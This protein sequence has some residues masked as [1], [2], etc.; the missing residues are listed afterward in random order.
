MA[1]TGVTKDQRKIFRSQMKVKIGKP[2]PYNDNINEMIS[3]WS[4]TVVELS[5]GKR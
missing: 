5:E 1:I 4:K 3:I 2:I